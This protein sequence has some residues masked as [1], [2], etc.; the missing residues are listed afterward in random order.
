LNWFPSKMTAAGE[1]RFIDSA[2]QSVVKKST[3]EEKKGIGTSMCNITYTFWEET[4]KNW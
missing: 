4:W 2:I 1:L 3:P